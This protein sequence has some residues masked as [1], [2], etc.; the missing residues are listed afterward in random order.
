MSAPAASANP[1][2]WIA[3]VAG[4]VVLATVIAAIA[5]MGPPSRQ[6]LMRLDERRVDD[7]NRIA[8]AVMAYHNEHGGPPASLDVLAAE[9]GVRLPRDPESKQPYGY[10]VLGKAE[11]RLCAQFDTDTSESTEPQAW[12]RAPWVHGRGRQCFKRRSD[13]LHV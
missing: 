13:V 8:N 3:I 5:V 12:L 4:I 10:E 6:R 11:Y 2:R 9:P 7:L 1:G